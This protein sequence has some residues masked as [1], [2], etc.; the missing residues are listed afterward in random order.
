MGPALGYD[1]GMRFLDT[2]PGC[3]TGTGTRMR[4]GIQL[5]DTAPG[6]APGYSTR[7]Q[8]QD[9]ALGYSTGTGTRI[10]HRDQH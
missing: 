2:A 8:H 4:T 1:T 5:W 10:W 7:M 6:P 9:T 3:G